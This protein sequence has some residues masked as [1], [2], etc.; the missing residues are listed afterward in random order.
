MDSKYAPAERASKEKL[1][2]DFELFENLPNVKEF[3]NALPY[4]ASVL[5]PERQ[6]V[7][8]N[9][10]LLEMLKV[11]SLENLLGL[12]P[13]EA[14]SCINS[15]KEP[16]RCGTSEG[17]K[18]CGAVN[19]ILK[20]QLTN[21]PVKDECRIA[22]II[23][24]EEIN[25]DLMIMASPF[26]INDTQYIILTLNDISSEIRKKMLER[27]FFHDVINTAGTLRGIIELMKSIHDENELRN[28]LSLAD[29]TTKDLVEEI[30][31]Q[32][33]LILAEN[34]ELVVNRS[35]VYS[36]NVI[37]DIV[38]QIHFHPVSEK[39]S[40]TVDKDS[41]DITFK[42]DE[43]IIKRVL[44]NMLKNALEATPERGQVIIGCF[45][46]KNEIVFR[47]HNDGY[48][49][50]DIQFQIFHRSFSTKGNNRGL[51]T[52]SMKLFTE[53]YL[54]GKILFESDF[55]KGTSFSIRLPV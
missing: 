37:R 6:V 46:D 31:S 32:R 8:V 14:I 30:Q 7:Y 22:S 51:G 2:K 54:R 41:D 50:R 45:R 4:V 44:N 11:D 27:I 52:Y 29:S 16:G 47:V 19:T 13:G 10:R 35:T 1:L 17:C 9:D 23:N 24:N 48:I 39:R 12:R 38:V 43:T 33:E 42:T 18:Y 25:Y 3:I 34:S 15:D 28:F 36:L 49:S 5:N 26:Y 40:V 21:S 20:C 55:D 53:K